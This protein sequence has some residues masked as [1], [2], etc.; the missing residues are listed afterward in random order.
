MSQLLTSAAVTLVPAPD[1]IPNSV[2]LQNE[3]FGTIN[4]TM[5]KIDVNLQLTDIDQGDSFETALSRW[6]GVISEADS[7][8]N[9][10]GAFPPPGN[11]T[12]AIPETISSIYVCAEITPI[13]S[14]TGGNDENVVGVAGPTL[15]RPR[16]ETNVTGTTLM[17]FVKLSPD[18]VD[19]SI[20]LD[21]IIHELGHVFGIGM[22]NL[23]CYLLNWSRLL[24]F[25]SGT[26]W[27]ENFVD[28]A[29]GRYI[30]EAGNR[31]WTDT[32]GCTQPLPISNDRGHWDETCFIDEILSPRLTQGRVASLSALTVAGIED[33][34]YE[35]DYNAADPYDEDN[36]DLPACCKDA[37]PD[38]QPKIALQKGMV[39][40]SNEARDKAIEYGKKLLSERS[41]MQLLSDEVHQADDSPIYVGDKV[42]MV[43]YRYGGRLFEVRVTQ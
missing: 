37:P 40:S 4:S 32:W 19:D 42:V 2:C 36:L 17:G 20:F 35:V 22:F 8:F 43:F 14:E 34:G 41:R 39:A 15:L 25:K 24:T 33:L 31:V 21:T 1:C 29:N 16:G 23:E 28:E 13:V 27:D 18:V 5:Y 11:C 7:P 38:M 3:D 10:S 30:G 26:R 9:V 6:Q 12:N